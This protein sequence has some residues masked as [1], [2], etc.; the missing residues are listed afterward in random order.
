MKEKAT[1]NLSLNKEKGISVFSFP[2]FLFVIFLL[3]WQF[4][5]MVM[6]I[7][8]DCN[9]CYRKIRRALFNI[10]GEIFITQFLNYS[11][12]GSVCF[13]VKPLLEKSFFYFIC[14][15][16]VQPKISLFESKTFSVDKK[17]L[18]YIHTIFFFFCKPFF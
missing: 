17:N 14:W 7:N 5:C 8:I 6:R 12:L 3:T 15:Y 2:I 4:C 1:S 10:E 16:L 18:L 9:G 11:N 13:D